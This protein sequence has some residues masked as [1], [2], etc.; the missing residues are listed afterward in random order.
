MK[1][2]T[3][4][5]AASG[6]VHTV[7]GTGVNISDINIAGSLLHVEEHSAFGDSGYQGFTSVP[8]LQDRLGNA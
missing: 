4:V 5:N 3:G 1:A 6:L 8:R 2:H 7:E